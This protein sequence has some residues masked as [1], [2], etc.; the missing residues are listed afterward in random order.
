[1]ID[2]I[3]KDRLLLKIGINPNARDPKPQAWRQR[4]LGVI[5]ERLGLWER[6]LR[7]AIPGVFE[8][9][10]YRYFRQRYL[11]VDLKRFREVEVAK[12]I[13]NTRNHIV[14]RVTLEDLGIDKNHP[15]YPRWNRMEFWEF[16]RKKGKLYGAIEACERFSLKF[17]PKSGVNTREYIKHLNAYPRNMRPTK[18]QAM[19]YKLI[20]Y[21][22]GMTLGQLQ[23]IREKHLSGDEWQ[24]LDL[25]TSLNHLAN[26]KL[27]GGERLGG[28]LEDRY[29]IGR[30]EYLRG[31]IEACRAGSLDFAGDVDQAELEEY[32]NW[33]REHGDGGIGIPE[34][35]LL[36]LI[37]H[38]GLVSQG[39]LNT[40]YTRDLSRNGGR[41]TWSKLTA[42][43]Y[44]TKLIDFELIEVVGKNG[45]VVKDLNLTKIPDDLRYRIH[46][47]FLLI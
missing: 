17:P 13:K 35:L 2:R 3:K 45:R 33:V 22:D 11:H 25:E 32:L 27:V 10:L 6:S 38:Y 15:Q 5:E 36:K 43:T 29:Y 19:L 12:G 47:G 1:V 37:S 39:E 23:R 46:R 28:G 9:D 14:R 40:L 30:A 18:A 42:R 26:L 8:E 24:K 31:K 7:G 34:R 20:L 44:L 16:K 4:A 41:S 21:F